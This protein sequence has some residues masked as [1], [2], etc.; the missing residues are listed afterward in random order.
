M[1]EWKDGVGANE[2]EDSFSME[3][4]EIEQSKVSIMRALVEVED[5]SAKVPSFFSQSYVSFFFFF[6]GF[7]RPLLV[8]FTI[9]LFVG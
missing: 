2:A 6:L 9:G 8:F 3:S 1:E 4:N 7:L 5:P